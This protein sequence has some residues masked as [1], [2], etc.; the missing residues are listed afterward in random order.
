MLIKAF[1]FAE[2]TV[3]QPFA[4]FHLVF[5]GIIGVIVFNESLTWPIVIGSSIVIIAGI[6]SYTLDNITKNLT[7]TKFKQ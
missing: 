5:A 7:D 4:Y 2:A 1:E 6:S 3:I